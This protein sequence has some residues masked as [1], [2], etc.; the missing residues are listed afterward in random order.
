MD[1]DRIIT[2]EGSG[3]SGAS[4]TCRSGQFETILT[5]EASASEKN[6]TQGELKNEQ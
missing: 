2:P 3:F 5:E 6:K 4:Q 1:E